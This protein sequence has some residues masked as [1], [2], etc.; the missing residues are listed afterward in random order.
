M[1][2]TE[3]SKVFLSMV[4]ASNNVIHVGRALRASFPSV[5]FSESAAIAIAPQDALTKRAPV[6]RETTT[7]IRTGP[8][9]HSAFTALDVVTK[10]PRP[11]MRTGVRICRHV[12]YADYGPEAAL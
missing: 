12:S 9:R 1:T 8:L 5:G 6:G 10:G 2:L 4:I 7:S 11:C 3:R